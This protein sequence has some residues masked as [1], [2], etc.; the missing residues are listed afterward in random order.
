MQVS[1]NCCWHERGSHVESHHPHHSVCLHVKSLKWKLAP[2]KHRQAPCI[3]AV[4]HLK[5]NWLNLYWCYFLA[6]PVTLVS[7]GQD[8][9]PHIQVVWSYVNLL[10]LFL[11]FFG[12]KISIS[13]N[14]LN[15]LHFFLPWKIFLNGNQER[16]ACSISCIISCI[17]YKQAI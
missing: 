3:R 14:E 2:K 15:L 13:L 1:R 4:T 11:L 5:L 8:D 10:Q 12:T 9:D 16:L 17:T 7:D 6:A